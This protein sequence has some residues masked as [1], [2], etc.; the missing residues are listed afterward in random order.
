MHDLPRVEAR[1]QSLC[2]GDG[3]IANP[4]LPGHF[5]LR[6]WSC[7]KILGK[8]FPEYVDMKIL[9]MTDGTLL[10]LRATYMHI[11]IRS[12]TLLRDVSAISARQ[13]SVVAS[14]LF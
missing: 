6:G 4:S 7:A 9:A 5:L 12:Q 2:E 3:A 10:S 1:G 14:H 8:A 13:V 11:P